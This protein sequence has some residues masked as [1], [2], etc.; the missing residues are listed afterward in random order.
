M[1]I[2]RELK[3]SGICTAEECF[4]DDASRLPHNIPSLILSD[5]KAV[6][7]LRE[8]GATTNIKT[9]SYVLTQIKESIK[10]HRLYVSY[11]KRTPAKEF[12]RCLSV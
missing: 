4:E 2:K 8:D 5:E 6:Y 12:I 1:R 7:L 3:K 10:I 9:A 11:E